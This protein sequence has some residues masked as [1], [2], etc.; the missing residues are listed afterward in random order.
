MCKSIWGG[1]INYLV[2]VVPRI[3][4]AEFLRTLPVMGNKL[5]LPKERPGQKTCANYYTT[6]GKYE[7]YIRGN[8][9]LSIPEAFDA[10]NWKTI[11]LMTTGV[12]T[13]KLTGGQ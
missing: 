13:R 12:K 1:L 8:A 3:T 6:S 9:F 4:M 10:M 7:D 5:Y 11:S 2:V